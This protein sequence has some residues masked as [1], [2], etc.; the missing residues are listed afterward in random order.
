MS[1]ADRSLLADL[2][3]WALGAALLSLCYRAARDGRRAVGPLAS[4]RDVQGGSGSR[5][6]APQRRAAA[7]AAGEEAGF[8][9]D[10]DPLLGALHRVSEGKGFAFRVDERDGP[11]I[12]NG[13]SIVF[14][15]GEWQ[16]VDMEMYAKLLACWTRER[17]GAQDRRN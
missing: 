3:R 1:H 4:Q 5:P 9:L 2:A 6:G 17:M 10:A 7:D 16:V 8:G 11:C 14:H 13:H 15:P 12:I